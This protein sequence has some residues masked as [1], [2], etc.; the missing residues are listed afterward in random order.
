MASSSDYKH[1]VPPVPLN[2]HYRES[3]KLILIETLDQL[4]ESFKKGY[5]MAWDTETTGL[6]PVESEIVGFS[7]SYDGITAYYCPVKHFDLAL[8]KPALDLFYQALKDAKLQL[9]YNARFDIRMMEY[10]GYDMSIMY[11]KDHST[12]QSYPKFIDVMNCSWLSDTNVLMPSLKASTLH[13]LGHQPPK[14]LETLGSEQNFQYVPA[15]DAYEYACF[16]DDTLIVTKHG[17]KQIKELKIG[18]WISTSNGYHKLLSILPQGIRKVVK[19][20]TPDKTSFICTED[21]KF[22]FQIGGDIFWVEA[23]DLDK[24]SFYNFYRGGVSLN[25]IGNTFNYDIGISPTALVKNA[26]VVVYLDE[27]LPV[28]DLSIENEHNFKLQC[29]LLAHNCEDAANTFN[30]FKVTYRYYKEAGIAA[31]LDNQC[32]YI[33]GQLEKQPLNMDI[34]YLV[35]LRDDVY[36]YVQETEQKI[37][38]IAGHTFKIGSNRELTQVFLE[39]GIDTG[40][41][42]KAGDMKTGIE[43]LNLYLRNHPDCELL[44]L[45]IEYKEKFKLYNSYLKTLVDIAKQQDT[46]PPRFS[47]KLQS[48]PCLTNNNLVLLKNKGLVSIED[49]KEQDYI[50]T[51][52]GYKRVLWNNSHKTKDVIRVIFDN[53]LFIEGTLHHPVL[54]NNGDD[55]NIKLEW[56]TLADLKEGEKVVFNHHTPTIYGEDD[57]DLLSFTY[58]LGFLFSPYMLMDLYDDDLFKKKINRFEYRMINNKYITNA[59][60]EDV[61]P[62]NLL[63]FITANK[64]ICWVKFIQGILTSVFNEEK[65]QKWNSKE[66]TQFILYSDNA[67]FLTIIMNMLFYLGIPSVIRYDGE[68]CFIVLNSMQSLTLF[69]NIIVEDSDSEYLKELFS[70]Y[71]STNYYIEYADSVVYSKEY[72]KDE[73]TV[74]DIEV[75]DVHEYVA[76][77]IVTHN[78]GRMSCLNKYSLVHTKQG[79]VPI[80]EITSDHDIE[81]DY[82]RYSKGSLINMG[83]KPFFKFS[84]ESGK[85]I[86]CTQDHR[87]LCPSDTGYVWRYAQDLK[88]GD[89]VCRTRV[90]YHGYRLN[91]ALYTYGFFLGDGSYYNSDKQE[92]LRLFFCEK[93][94]DAMDLIK[95]YLDYI[96]VKSRLYKE[97]DNLWSLSIY[98]KALVI[99]R[100]YFPIANVK[101]SERDIDFSWIHS[102]EDAFSVIAGVYQ[103]EGE[104]YIRPSDGKMNSSLNVTSYKLVVSLQKLADYI[105]IRTRIHSIK[106]DHVKHPTHNPQWKLQFCVKSFRKYL[107]SSLS[108]RINTKKDVPKFLTESLN[109]LPKSLWSEGEHFKFKAMFHNKRYSLYSVIRLCED[110]DLPIEVYDYEKITH[111]EDAGIQEAYTLSVEDSKHQYIAEGVINHNC[112]KDAKNTYFAPVN[113]Q[114]LEENTIIKT[115]NGNKKIKDVTENDLV[116]DGFKY[117]PCKPLGSK[118][119]YCYKIKTLWGEIEASLEHQFLTLNYNTYELEF[120]T[121]EECINFHYPLVRDSQSLGSS[122]DDIY[123]HIEYRSLYH[124][125][126]SLALDKYKYYLDLYKDYKFDIIQD[127]SHEFWNKK[128]DPTWLIRTVYDLYVPTYNQFTANGYIVH[129]SIPKPKSTKCYGRKATP[130]EIENKQDILGWMFSPDHPEWSPGKVVEG[131]SDHLNVRRAFLPQHPEDGDYVVSVDMCLEGGSP[132]Q[133]KRG[134]IGISELKVG[135]FVLSPQGW[136][137]VIRVMQTGVKKLIKVYP[138]N[139]GQAVYCTENHHF[140]L[141][142]EKVEAKD[143]ENPLP[144]VKFSSWVQNLQDIHLL[145]DKLSEVRSIPLPKDKVSYI[146]ENKLEYI[147]VDAIQKYTRS[148]ILRMCG[149]EPTNISFLR[150]FTTLDHVHI[151]PKNDVR[152]NNIFNGNSTPTS[153]YLFGYILGDGN[154]SIRRENYITLNITSKDYQHLVQISNVLGDG[155]SLRYHEKNCNMWWSIDIPDRNL[156]GRLIELGISKRKSTEPSNIDFNWLGDNFRHFIRGLFDSDGY[157]RVTSS[158]DLSFVGH[159]SYIKDIQRLI[160]G[161]WK[162]KYTDSLSYLFLQGTIDQK[163][164]IYSYLYKDATIWLQRK[165]D[166]IEQWFIDKFGDIILPVWN[167]TVNTEDHLYY[168]NGVLTSNCSEELRIVTNLYKERAWADVIN[169]GGDLH[170]ANSDAIFGK[171]N[172]TKET[173]KKAKCI[174]GKSLVFTTKGIKKLEDLSDKRIVGEPQSIDYIVAT[175]EGMC[176]ATHFIYNGEKNIKILHFKDA[177]VLEATP[178]HLVQSKGILKRIDELGIGDVVDYGI[179]VIEKEIVKIEESISEVF[180][181]TV[182]NKSHLFYANGF[183]VHNCAA[184]GMLYGQEYQGFQRKFPDMTLDEAKEF[185][186]KFKRAIPNIIRGQ[187]RTLSEAKRTGTFYTAFGRPRR[188]KHYLTSSDYREQAFGK[189]TCMNGIIQGTAADVLKL[190]FVRLWDYLFTKYPDVKFICTIHDEINYSVPRRLVKE[191]IPIIIKCMTVRLSTDLVAL[192]CSLSAGKSLGEIIPFKYNFET[193]EFEPEW[194]EDTRKDKHEEDTEDENELINKEEESIEEIDSKMFDL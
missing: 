168:V 185:M 11:P 114:C 103:A 73:M 51:Q 123:H 167:I 72:I 46:V 49:V 28:F 55:V 82:N 48:V 125:R 102:K 65:A 19:V 175:P 116:W 132:V 67:I 110:S 8:G 142:G 135:D 21:H 17:L 71:N 117:V 92:V 170:H 163:K 90:T 158:L 33:I 136:V 160:N 43:V 45:L 184:F 31:K 24:I 169:T 98:K 137:E 171:E 122:F 34:D 99:L 81:V 75:E 165:R 63:E 134:Y 104:K 154:L 166:I 84:L 182:D 58:F 69:K 124:L 95:N 126:Q 113:L 29:G 83:E 111:I 77:G 172:Y 7:Y 13:F 133:T 47:Y 36:K 10:S 94:L 87:F 91:L 79:L 190:E 105:G 130:E 15:R 162:Y 146:K 60:K 152:W 57:E 164:F 40:E 180:D 131:M 97:K 76:N 70:S 59:H 188:V 52:Y 74:Y 143:I 27:E 147:I 115:N 78:T 144:T 179:D 96:H 161:S 1:F 155:V 100:K 187:Q 120:H 18:D 106:I 112:G 177:S 86:E 173:R 140:I 186:A 61:N 12:G 14:F 4:K 5:V 192:D 20:I 129:N 174:S 44:T 89:S 119:E 191:V 88:E 183:I 37:Y 9:L 109:S 80:T 178:D 26:C 128:L 2:P 139:G 41:R 85:I 148:K 156:C 6:N 32:V 145:E 42:T 30:L 62:S 150:K 157:V 159:D 22:A 93:D 181:L 107:N 127:C 189:R 121:L 101:Q 141:N 66:L 138:D 3:L 35:K 108:F 56:A 54:V 149:L 193:K 38:D 23:R 118:R 39:Q 16:T 68:K 176:K 53:G 64:P 50:W 194:E 151:R 153:A 25:E